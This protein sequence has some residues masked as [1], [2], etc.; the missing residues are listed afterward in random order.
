MAQTAD[1]NYHCERCQGTFPNCVRKF[2]FSATLTDDSSTTWV[3]LFDDQARVL[4][5]GISADDVY[6]KTYA[7]GDIDSYNAYFDKALFSE[8]I[9][10][11]KVKQEMVQDE[12]RIKTS[13]YALHPV[14]YVKESK[15]LL[16]AIRKLQ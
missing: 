4:L 12:M 5:E 6:E 14:D 3:S 2:I 16:Q 13:V 9:F 7:Q 15:E 1:G 8:W 10:T 11:C